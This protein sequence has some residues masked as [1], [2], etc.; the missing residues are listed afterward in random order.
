LIT[1]KRIYL[2]SKMLKGEVIDLSSKNKYNVSFF[3]D[4]SIDTIR[5]KIGIALDIHHDRLYILVGI[6]LPADYYTEDPRHWEGLFE[7]MSFNNEP[8]E[9]DVF[10]EYQLQYRTPTTSVAFQA[11]DKTEWMS[12]PE[13]LTPIFESSQE[14]IEYRIL[15]VEETKS[16]ILPLSN[17]S[18]TLVSKIAPVKL[19]IPENTK[20][21][22]S[23]YDSKQF[24]RFLVRPYDEAAETNAFVYYPLLRSTTPSKLSEEA[25]R[26]I[27]KNS[28]VLDDLLKLKVPEPS[29]VSILRTRFYLPWVDTDFGSAVRT[30]FEQMF[31]GITVSKEL[32]CITMFTSKDQIS[33][34]KFF[35]EDAKNKTPFL[36]MSLWGSWWS[37]KPVRNIPSL[38]LFRGTG[39]NHF[40]RVTI[41]ASDM[42]V[43]TYRPEGNNETIEQL[44]RQVFDWI[45]S[46][47]AI[48]PFLSKQDI[49][50]TRWV[51]QDVSYIAKYS[52]K[53]EEFDLLRF[54]CISNI[55]DISD[56][57]KS[58]F[59]FLRTDHSNN[60]LSAIEVKILQMLKES[61]GNLSPNVVSEELAIPIQ[62]A[63]E[64]ILQ[65]QNRIDEDPRLGEKAF[66]GYPSMRLG[67]D[68]VLVSAVS[69]IEKMLGYTNLLRFILSNP[70]SGELDTLCPKR[71]EKVSATTAII[72]AENLQ[73]DA[74]VAEEYSDL[75]AFLEEENGEEEDIEEK[76]VASPEN[77]AKISTDQKQGTTYNY[78]KARLQKFD[79]VTFNPTGSL[80]PKKCEKNHQ[81]IIL[82]DDEVKRISGKPYDLVKDLPEEQKIKIENPSG[83][84]IC[85][86]YWCMH[87]NIPLSDSQLI[88][89]DDVKCPVC[90]GKLQTNANDNPREF[91]LIKRETGFLYP[92]YIDYKSPH[93][94]NP[95][96]CCFKRS[97]VKKNNKVE[98]LDD[99]YYVLG[100]EKAAKVD[101][102]AFIPE[103]IIQSLHINE[104]Y[105][106][107]NRK[108]ESVSRLM[109][110]NK[111]FFRTGLGRPSE[112][113]AKLI[114]ITQKIPSPREAI[115][116]ILKCSFLSTWRKVGT[117]H[118]DAISN[119]LARINT[120]VL[121]QDGLSR[122]ISGIDEAF[123][124]QEL[125]LLEE[126]EYS[127]LVLNCDVF[128]IQS[129]TSTLGCMFYTPMV[130]SRSRAVVILETESELN[131]LVY[132]ERK[133][134]GFDFQANIYKTPFTSDTTV[135]L[136]KLRN[137]ACKLKVP[138]YNDALIVIQQILPTIGADDYM[139]ILDPYERGQ[140]LYVPNKLILPFKSTPLPD[141]GQAKIS[142][143]SEI[144]TENLPEYASITE[145]LT[146]ARKTS[147]GYTFKEDVY[148]NANQRV[149]ILLES[150][151]RIPIK[152]S[153]TTDLQENGE[154]VETIR[155]STES[156]LTFGKESLELK[157]Q[158]SEVSYSA[159]IYD[160]LLF[161]LSNDLETEYNDLKQSLLDVSPKLSVVNPLLKKWFDE[162]VTFMNIKDPK[163]FVSK[164]R[165]PCNDKCD[166][167]LCGWDGDICKVK[168]GTQLH[169]DKL[170]HKLLTTL[171]DNSKIRAMVLDGRT[172]PFF[173]TILYLELPHEVILTDTEL[174]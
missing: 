88:K 124:K 128:R 119:E 94:G 116:T 84:V 73:K 87:D 78:F 148:N 154:V 18:T 172:T 96:P 170:F 97:R 37:V 157:R 136:E 40:D 156:E 26:L 54:N 155:E 146:T 107:F 162:T 121:V 16:Y 43:A 144:Q 152:P 10:S 151:L 72:P 108:K 58:Q 112:N 164:I 42:V 71:S 33:R 135:E 118:L 92:G 129:E 60:G 104:T 44:Q 91:P 68:Y 127:A 102:I 75:F 25:V 174:D 22:S 61:R 53:L 169:P 50:V 145:I 39:K 20:L 103:N 76:E 2:K 27:Q 101:R 111:G 122:I 64:V 161:Q 98:K 117:E 90:N 34:H 167:E 153:D 100:S 5:Q 3:D 115:A 131:I 48:L 143:Y 6:K 173:S 8:L 81:P 85:P 74:V 57:T 132:T 105:E 41:T 28:N 1:T 36:D 140:A 49:T 4:D 23:F 159:E 93:N 63:K 30:R 120:D 114:G 147:D 70:E 55:F 13:V 163:Q 11:F 69:N 99:K 80:Y 86:E 24:V 31:Y 79:P 123:H 165:E 35:T 52:E 106:S 7:R 137:A 166:G 139:I 15:G 158:S 77:V 59:N 150:G 56:K 17:I 82:S 83:V 141:V 95:M 65:V 47:D 171:I 46:F 66:R 62:T 126:L 67:P 160:F 45:Q 168:I 133:S 51:L 32:P 138:S 14:F 89:D 29:E 142:G 110:P 12:S 130:R 21:F 38:I 9:T 113:L 134:R 19:P 125:S 149:E 109:S